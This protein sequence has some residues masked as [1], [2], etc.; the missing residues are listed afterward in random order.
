MSRLK[1]QLGVFAKYWLPGF[2]KKRLAA[3]EG[4]LRAAQL[5]NAFLAATLRRFSASGQRRVLGF[6][7]K[8]KQT[9]FQS[10]AGPAWLLQSQVA[11]DL[12]QR[13]DYYFQG[14]FGNGQEQVL[15]LGAD[16]PHLPL[17]LIRQAYKA[18][19][20][21]DVVLGPSR[22]GGYYLIGLN[23]PFP[24]LFLEVD[25][26]TSRVW[27]Q[28]TNKLSHS[29]HHFAELPEWYDI[30][31]REDLDCLIGDLTGSVCVDPHLRWLRDRIRELQATADGV[32]E[33]Y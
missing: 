19:Q 13:M 31:D 20:D 11:G 26:G 8:E 10:L 27:N 14:A 5:Y 28:T 1:Q 22:D 16:S 23:R 21:T 32:D 7:P 24:E 9:E 15:L 17:N 2:V 29:G 3:T 4:E 33:K 18:L 30:D 6:T 25:W 12:G